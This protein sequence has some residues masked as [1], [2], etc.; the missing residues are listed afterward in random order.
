MALM[1]VT[2]EYTADLYPCR[3]I[4]NAEGTALASVLVF[5]F[6]PSC[7]PD[8]EPH[9]IVKYEECADKAI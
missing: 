5:R 3:N 8:S 4:L 9:L 7:E 6:S 2:T 1:S